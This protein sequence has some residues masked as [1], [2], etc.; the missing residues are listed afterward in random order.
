MPLQKAIG[1]A[2]LLSAVMA[3]SGVAGHLFGDAPLECRSGCTGYIYLPAVAAI[4][5]SGVLIAPLGARI[6]QILPVLLLR[7]LFGCV[8]I[9]AAVHLAVKGLPLATLPSEAGMLLARLAGPAEAG[10]PVGSAPPYFLSGE[11]RQNPD[12]LIA[13]FGPRQAFLPLAAPWS[14]GRSPVRLFVFS[15]V[16]SMGDTAPWVAD[17]PKGSSVATACAAINMPL[18]TRRN[19]RGG[20]LVSR[21]G[22]AQAE[23]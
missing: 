7:R 6:M 11:I 22:A 19:R 20:E 2:T 17:I 16:Q 18:P 3:I 5:M 15:P 8:L 10:P 21:R 9:A 23:R 12:A 1:T 14:T 13:E 4:G